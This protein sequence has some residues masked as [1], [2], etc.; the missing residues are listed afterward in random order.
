MKHITRATFK[1]DK[2]FPAVKAAVEEIL[3]RQDY[4]SVV[5]VYLQM[6]AMTKAAH[7]DWRFGRTPFLERVIEGGLGKAYRVLHIL[8][9]Y[10]EDLRL[11]PSQTVYKQ[12]GQ[13]RKIIPLRF[14]KYGVP[15]VEELYRTHYVVAY[16]KTERAK[17]GGDATG[18][19]ESRS[20]S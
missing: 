7:D 11:K 12:W 19:D 1:T 9:L 10:A 5:D 14:S 20:H 3:T 2:H 17:A 6:G 15:S 16:Q 18:S 4:V 8:R 13:G